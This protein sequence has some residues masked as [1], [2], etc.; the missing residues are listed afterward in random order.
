MLN[1]LTVLNSLLEKPARAL[2][3]DLDG[4][5]VDSVP[6][7]AAAIDAMLDDMGYALAGEQRVRH[8]IGN[9]AIKLVQR[10]LAHARQA[11]AS[12]SSAESVQDWQEAHQ[13]FLDH[14]GRLSPDFSRLY[15]GVLEAI[16][17]WHQQGVT[18]AVVTN[19]PRQFV[20]DILQHFALDTFF[21]VIVGG[22]C[23]PQRKPSPEPLFFA[24]EQLSVSASECIMIGDSQ[25]DVGAARAAGIPVACVSYGYNHGEPIEQAKPDIVIDSLIELL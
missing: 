13:C 4:T 3:F 2:L 12:E 16:K 7:L 24:C 5:L 1:A 23:L 18:M 25:N 14:Y 19:K 8:W 22:D 21:P 9:G 10:S 15:P 20:P 17:A 11:D 6:D